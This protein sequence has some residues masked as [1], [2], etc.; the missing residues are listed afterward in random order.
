MCVYQG[1]VGFLFNIEP[2]TNIYMRIL[3]DM[4]FKKQEPRHLVNMEISIELVT[5]IVH[6]ITQ[7]NF[8]DRNWDRVLFLI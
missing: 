4:G 1:K 6:T 3:K 8:K 7:I 2:I 5:R